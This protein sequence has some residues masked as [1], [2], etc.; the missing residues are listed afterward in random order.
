MATLICV[1][2]VYGVHV[3]AR[4]DE[5]LADNFPDPP[6][7]EDAALACLR[8][9]RTPVVIAG[10]TTVAGFGALLLSDTP[11]IRE[12]GAASALGIAAV[13]TLAITAVPAALAMLQ[14]FLGL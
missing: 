3:I 7:P 5:I 11:A 2:S 4:F 10:A 8:Y 12:L 6:A 1:G 9:V 14:Q 13:T